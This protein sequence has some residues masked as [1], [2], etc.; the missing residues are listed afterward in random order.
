MS[1]KDLSKKNQQVT[2]VL[3]DD[4]RRELEILFDRLLVQD[5]DGLSLQPY[6]QSLQSVLRGRDK[7]TAALLEKLGKN[8]SLAGFKAFLVLSEQI[9]GKNFKKVARQAGYRFRQKGYSDTRPSS[10]AAQVVLVPKESRRVVTH[11]VP[12]L[13]VDWFVTGLFPGEAGG[14]PISVSA[15]GENRFSQLTVRVVESSQNAYREFIRKLGEHMTPRV[16]YEVP[17]WHAARIYFEM[18]EFHGD[19][20][21]SPQAEYAKKILKPF[22]DPRKRPYV[23]DFFATSEQLELQ[24]S[25]RVPAALFENLPSSSV[26]L[27]SDVLLPYR[28]RM[29]QIEQSVL[30]VRE[31]IQRQRVAEILSQAVDELITGPGRFYY[32]RLFEE[33]ALTFRFAQK[34]DLSQVAW[35]VARHLAGSSRAGEAQVLTELV[36]ASLHW[37]WPREFPAG[38]E[39]QEAFERTAAGLI[40]PR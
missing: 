17:P 4:E 7:L 37:H 28:Q 9:E 30:V 8:P 12:A 33:A 20:P 25:G 15:Y 31:E 21:V 3:S 18:L 5:P 2:M 1:A 22:Y 35:M 11:L 14:E 19:R 6:L 27:P 10:A 32:Q 24:V 36:A 23:Y 16:P 13:D 26:L 39:M 34:D 29:L 38:E 40:I